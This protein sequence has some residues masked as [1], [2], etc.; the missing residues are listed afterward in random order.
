MRHIGSA[1]VLVVV[2]HVEHSAHANDTEPGHVK[3]AV[4]CELRKTAL[5]ACLILVNNEVLGRVVFLHVPSAF[6]RVEVDY[7]V[8]G[9]AAGGHQGYKRSVVV[10]VGNEI[11]DACERPA[12]VLEGYFDVVS[13]ARLEV[14]LRHFVAVFVYFHRLLCVGRHFVVHR[15]LRVRPGEYLAV[16][17]NRYHF[18]IRL[19]RVGRV[20][21]GV[22]YGVRADFGGHFAALDVEL[23][24]V[25]VFD[26]DVFGDVRTVGVSGHRRDVERGTLKRGHSAALLGRAES[27][28]GKANRRRAVDD[29]DSERVGFVLHGDGNY[30]RAYLD[31][32]NHPA[33]DF[34]RIVFRSG[35]G[36]NGVGRI[37]VARVESRGYR[38][39]RSVLPIGF[40]F[41]LVAYAYAL[42]CRGKNGNRN[43][44]GNAALSR[45]GN[46]R[47]A[48][49]AARECGAVYRNHVGIVGHYAQLAVF[50]VVYV[51]GVEAQHKR[52]RRFLVLA[53]G[54]KR[55]FV[56]DSHGFERRSDG[57]FKG[58]GEH[59]YSDGDGSRTAAD[60]ADCRAVDRDYGGVAR[61][62]RVLG[63]RQRIA[64]RREGNLDVT[65][66]FALYPRRSQRFLIGYFKRFYPLC[67]ASRP[68]Y[69]AVL[70]CNAGVMPLQYN[71]LVP[72][73]ERGGAVRALG[74]VR[75]DG[76][77]SREALI[78][79]CE[80]LRGKRDFGVIV[81]EF[82]ADRES[83][84]RTSVRACT[85]LVPLIGL[86]KRAAAE[87]ES[88]E[89]RVFIIFRT[90][91]NS[92][93]SR[94]AVPHTRTH[95]EN[96]SSAAAGSRGCLVIPTESE[97]AVEP[98]IR[99]YHTA[100]EVSVVFG[101]VE[102]DS[103]LGGCVVLGE[104]AVI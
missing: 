44:V 73:V 96:H 88:V 7:L 57:H 60:G 17:V 68:I 36:G 89:R 103:A 86:G 9:V 77:H 64:F 53:P 32:L 100:V 70:A 34:Y 66:A 72:P 69:V 23:G 54:N 80:R 101:E 22:G 87:K 31:G 95:F 39:P 85:R 35:D 10:V 84:S 15:E 83:R 81:E 47:R 21:D 76:N 52:A 49:V 51:G 98:H 5:I 58:I 74:C 13:V 78:G 19:G 104:V 1:D 55:G 48:S 94:I 33:V 61:G 27:V 26:N 46:L 8:I 50:E 4:L 16:D 12:G 37:V 71:G 38:A 14:E 43:L 97:I 63:V 11:R 75:A 24:L 6:V 25:G 40:E 30:R 91:L 92:A 2:E 59:A 45:D 42:N 56:L 3:I 82:T 65:R 102:V 20:F 67:R 90:E 79:V 28:A 62:Y 99:A 18:G 29:G 93:Y 41:G